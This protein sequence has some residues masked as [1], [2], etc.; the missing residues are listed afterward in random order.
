MHLGEY[1]FSGCRRL[2]NATATL[3]GCDDGLGFLELA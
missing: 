3:F 2:T 1:L